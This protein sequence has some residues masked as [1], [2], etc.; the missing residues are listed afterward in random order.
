MKMKMKRLCFNYLLVI[1][2]VLDK[3]KASGNALNSVLGKVAKE[4]QHKYQNICVTFQQWKKMSQLMMYFIHLTLCRFA[5]ST[6]SSLAFSNVMGWLSRRAAKAFGG[7]WCFSFSSLCIVDNTITCKDNGIKI[8][9]H[10]FALVV[11]RFVSSA[12]THAL[13]SHIFNRSLAPTNTFASH[14]IDTILVC[15]YDCLQNELIVAMERDSIFILIE[16]SMWF[17]SHENEK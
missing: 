8:L 15:I 13:T 14:W 16:K 7:V 9:R 11:C 10:C 5:C 4:Q 2:K 3:S 17:V 6:V 1:A 12:K